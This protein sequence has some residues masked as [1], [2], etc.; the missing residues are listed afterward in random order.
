MPV[1]ESPRIAT[2]H[3]EVEVRAVVQTLS[4]YGPLPEKTL[5]GLVEGAHWRHG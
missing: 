3:L 1:S 5:E 4:S 2:T